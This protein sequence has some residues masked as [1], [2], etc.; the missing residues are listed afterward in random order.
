MRHPALLVVNVCYLPRIYDFVLL[1][2]LHRIGKP[3]RRPPRVEHLDVMVKRDECDQTGDDHSTLMPGLRSNIILNAGPS[4]AVA[5]RLI[6]RQHHQ[7]GSR[8]MKR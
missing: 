4:L 3:R 8:F 7:V 6:K 2:E 1:Q 5:V